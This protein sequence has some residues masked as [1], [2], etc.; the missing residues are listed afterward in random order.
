MNR[1]HRSIWNSSLGAWVAVFD[2]TAARG[3]RSSGASLALAGG[4]ALALAL[5]IRS[6]PAL[7][8]GNGGSSTVTAGSSGVPSTD[9]GAGAGGSGVV[10]TR[11]AGGVGAG[12][13]GGNGGAG[14]A[15]GGGGGGGATGFRSPTSAISNPSTG[16][17][18]GNG[19]TSS[20]IGGGGG[21]GGAGVVLTEVGVSVTSSSVITGG[22]GG[23]GGTNGGRGG[24]GG[25]G[26][27]VQTGEG[28]FS[29][30]G[31]VTG[32]SGGT[33][34]G[35]GTAGSNGGRGEGLAAAGIPNIAAEGGAGIIGSRM[36]LINSGS[37]SGG[38][39]GDGST[40]ANAITF[41]GGSNSLTLQTGS[42]LT[43]GVEIRSGATANIISEVTN[44]NLTNNLLLGGNGTIDTQANAMTMSGV[45]S[46]AGALTKT[47][48]G[49]LTLTGA[50]SYTG[51]TTVIG[52]TLQAGAPSALAANSDY[53]VNAG[54][55]LDLNDNSQT[56]QSLAGDAT[57]KVTLGT[58]TLTTSSSTTFEGQ[59][60]GVGRL[61]KTGTG[62]M[63]LSGASTY[64]GGTTVYGGGLAVT[65]NAALGTGALTVGGASTLSGSGNTL[66]NAV[67]LNAGLTVNGSAALTL[68]GVISGTGGL[69]KTGAGN[70]VLTG[71]NTYSGATSVNAGTLSVNGSIGS[72]AVTVNSGGILGGKGTVGSTSIAIG[73]VL[74]PGNSIGTLNVIGNLNFAVGSIYR[75]EVDA[76]GANDR[77]NATGTAALNGTVDVQANAG[78]YAA[79]TSYTLLNANGGVTGT[80]ASVT[81]NL[82][83]LTPS[84]GYTAN[85]V[86]LSLA[87]NEISFASVA[88]TPNQKSV[89]TA[90]ENFGST[91]DAGT[92]KTALTGL[93]AAQARAAY[94]P[95][96]G[97]GI[98]GLARS[99][100]S[101][102]NS[103]GGQLQSRLGSLQGA[104]VTSLAALGQRPLLLA[105]SDPLAGLSELMAQAPVA[106]STRSSSTLADNAGKGFWL[107]GYGGYQKSESDGNAAASSQRDSGVSAGFDMEVKDGLR[108]GAAVNAGKA[109]LS[110]D[111]NESGNARSTAL[112]VYGSYAAGPWT[113]SGSASYAWGSNH[114]DRNIVIGALSRTASSD[115]ESNTLSAYGE[116]NYAIP[117][118]GWTLQPLAA[119][120]V[121]R[122]K[123]DG[124]AE[125][126]ASALNLQVAGQTITSTRS[127]VGARASFEAGP[128]TLEPRLAWSHEFGDVNAPITAR[129]QGA[130]ATPFQA[131]GTVLK[132]DA[133]IVGLGA[134]STVSQ[135]VSLFADLQAEVTSGQHNLTALF[136]LR[137]RW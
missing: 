55:T 9:G 98:S 5:L 60:T 70:L 78:T 46:G 10:G 86:T 23:N 112:A 77:V 109:R 110:T 49:V 19:G 11:G 58:A 73:G 69:T 80:F 57:S 65:N 38:L 51:T 114:M 35:G 118:N 79:N 24:G 122:Y 44:L 116:A 81:S 34:A 68:G 130:S 61:V 45:V 66:S 36:T 37:I 41:S 75:V 107:R 123:A 125:T 59:I 84:L 72:S 64:L 4:T 121:S 53:T 56:I 29:N 20:N 42:S 133:L 124:F 102:A 50:N 136:G 87:R 128:V 2:I 89:A 48:A 91:G 120:A 83:F 115:F 105:S 94:E 15:R 95:A 28:T 7:A 12:S 92:V 21:G 97:A 104:G 31:I 18:G 82:A 1:A 33:A 74:A 47:G 17:N 117:M 132:R 13:H 54:A 62:T 32:G 85:N 52:G 119:L 14:T 22:N 131:S 27:L 40:R 3:K 16:G 71:T 30:S 134:Q 6:A 43:G 106:G 135:G 88:A 127:I 99:G 100:M 108:L 129:L 111:N 93:T 103:F 101:F 67:V 63:T 96:S 137:S 126:G 26:V 25:A 113:F 76:S 90:L 8:G 39:S